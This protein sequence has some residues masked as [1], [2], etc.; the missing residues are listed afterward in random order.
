M[1]AARAGGSAAGARRGRE[2][3]EPAVT[4]GGAPERALPVSAL[5]TA[6]KD[7]LEGAFPPLWVS[8]EVSN[9]TRHR[10]GHWYFTLKDRLASMDCVVW[11]RD[12][13][14]LPAAPDDGMQVVA[15]GQLTM[16]AARSR[17]QF[18]VRGME[19]EGEGLWRKALERVKAALE[20][21]GLLD[22]AR[23]RPIPRFP[24]VVGVVTSVDG[25][26]MHDVVSVI[27]RRNP[28]IDVVVIPAAVQGEAA[29]AS[30][31]RA[32]EMAARW[33]G[34]DVL[35]IGRGGGSR[36]DLW[37]FNDEGVA[38]AIAASPT[39][40]VSAVGHEIDITI[41][42]L[43]ADVRAATPSAAA[44]LVTPMLNDLRRDLQALSASMGASLR[45]RV[46]AGRN[47]SA[48]A[49]REIRGRAQRVL[50]RGRERLGGAAS[51]VNALSPLAILQR[52][53]AFPRSVGGAAMSRVAHYAPGARFELVLID[54]CVDA[55]AVCVRPG[56]LR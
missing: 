17:V 44:E 32:L 25:A 39:P 22:P 47:D 26:A 6:A 5:A 50:D 48:R 27:A 46:E 52:G 19:A 18:A 14:A 33:G 54:G 29:P 24:R 42:D 51:R 12:Q 40:T 10:N 16:W 28:S 43:V 21:D 35:I 41:A 49:A 53:Y 11:S 9:F 23:K 15:F 30:L 2:R 7:A 20:A 8:G 38:R 13:R 34:A 56:G 55:E 31:V 4:P 3:A 1:G 37:A 45:R 36:E